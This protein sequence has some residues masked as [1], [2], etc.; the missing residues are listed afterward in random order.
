MSALD[1]MQDA[2]LGNGPFPATDQYNTPT[3]MYQQFD[4]KSQ[5]HD[6]FKNEQDI[7][8]QFFNVDSMSD[9]LEQ[10]QNSQQGVLQVP[11]EGQ[12]EDYW[13]HA[14]AKGNFRTGLTPGG[15][16]LNLNLDDI[17]GNNQGWNMPLNMGMGDSIQP[18]QQQGPFNYPE[19]QQ[20]WQ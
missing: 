11:N 16:G 17:F 9:R 10:T 1:T 3:S 4:R 5:F 12:A 7:P 2:P 19:Q 8:Q 18:H 15:P 13:G 14:P 6:S 20:Q